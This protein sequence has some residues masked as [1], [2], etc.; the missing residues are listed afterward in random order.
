[1]KLYRKIFLEIK[2]KNQTEPNQ[3][4]LNPQNFIVYFY[5]RIKNKIVRKKKYFIF[6]YRIK[7]YDKMGVRV[8]T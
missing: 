6:L 2:R 8:V 3:N 7:N 5:I 4:R 1:M